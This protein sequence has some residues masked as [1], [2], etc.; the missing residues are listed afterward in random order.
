VRVTRRNEV[1]RQRLSGLKNKNKV[2]VR[3]SGIPEFFADT[4]DEVLVV[5]DYDNPTTI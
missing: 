4:R 5:G 2:E 3:D 1:L